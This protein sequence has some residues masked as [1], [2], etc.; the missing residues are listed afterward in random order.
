MGEMMRPNLVNLHT[1]VL[2]S[3]QLPSETAPLLIAIPPCQTPPV[4]PKGRMAVSPFR[5]PSSCPISS[6]HSVQLSASLPHQ[7]Q[8]TAM[9]QVDSVLIGDPA[10]LAPLLEDHHPEEKG[11]FVSKGSQMHH[12]SIGM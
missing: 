3:N 12:Q 6:Q 7:H 2:K 8:D 4:M 11:N 5:L 9:A 1:T 10:C